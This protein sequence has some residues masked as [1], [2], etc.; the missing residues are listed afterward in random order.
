MDRKII[1]KV[2][3][4]ILAFT[5][6]FANVAILGIYTQEVY[7]ANVEL[8]E[9]STKVE[10]ANIEFDAYFLQEGEMKHSKQVD[11]RANNDKLNLRIKV[12]EGYLSNAQVTLANA[13]FKLKATDEELDLV[14]AIDTENRSNFIK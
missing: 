14:Q 3:A 11:V 5:L 9:Q 2:L 6:S 4:A 13:N 12:S 10:K 1:T 8:E 7:A